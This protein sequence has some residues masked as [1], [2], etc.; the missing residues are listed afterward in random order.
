MLRPRVDKRRGPQTTV[1][2]ASQVNTAQLM[3]PL[4]HSLRHYGPR[5]YDR[6]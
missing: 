6:H 2:G 5:V 3:D 1:N 4:A